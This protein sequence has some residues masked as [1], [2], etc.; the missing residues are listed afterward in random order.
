MINDLN[1]WN[2]LS[3]DFGMIKDFICYFNK[4]FFLSHLVEPEKGPQQKV[5]G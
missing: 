4:Y 2:D 3:R 5:R 1:K